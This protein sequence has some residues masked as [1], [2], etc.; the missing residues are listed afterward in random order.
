[1]NDLTNES[2]K[3]RS[4]ISEIFDY[5]EIFV[6]AACAVLLVFSAAL[7]LCN[8]DGGSM[9]DTLEEGEMLIIS[10]FFYTPDNGDVVV[11]HQTDSNLSGYNKPLVK[12]VI[13]TEGQWVYIEYGF[14]NEMSV[15]VSDDETI[16]ESDLIDEPYVNLD[17]GP[18]QYQNHYKAKVPEGCVF[19]MG[20]HRYNSADSRHHEISFVD[21]RRILGK[22]LLRVTPLS[23]FGVIN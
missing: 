19:V 5:V 2:P 17:P 16:D 21:Q 9:N 12:R 23:K 7:R 14:D 22:V 13:A 4:I 3:K 20:D 8:V 18:A 15:Y 11:F 10:D 1:M 6:F